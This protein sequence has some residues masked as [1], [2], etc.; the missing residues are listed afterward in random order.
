MTTKVEVRDDGMIVKNSKEIGKI[1]E[2][3]ST[4]FVKNPYTLKQHKIKLF[5]GATVKLAYGGIKRGKFCETCHLQCAWGANCVSYK[6][7][8]C[9]KNPEFKDIGF[10]IF[11]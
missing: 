4:D 2:F 5:S 10:Y 3:M 6:K 11:E 1:A 7:E 9:R 8:A